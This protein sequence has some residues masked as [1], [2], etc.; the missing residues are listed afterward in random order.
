M[1]ISIFMQILIDL[2]L[3]MIFNTAYS[4]VSQMLKEK[5]LSNTAPNS[6]TAKLRY[7]KSRLNEKG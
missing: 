7:I 1:Y 6:Q 4:K 5:L 2:I 3:G